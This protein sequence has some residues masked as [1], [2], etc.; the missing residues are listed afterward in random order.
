M[1]VISTKANKVPYG[2]PESR[3]RYVSGYVL[4]NG[5][6]LLES[7]R[8]T[9]GKYRAGAGMDGMYLQTGRLFEPVHGA[10]GNLVG[11]S[12]C[13]PTPGTNRGMI[14]RGKENG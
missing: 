10:D 9:E 3:R 4:N 6:V 7:E 11:F 12:E 1:K 8:D 5:L 2:W 14:E 13:T